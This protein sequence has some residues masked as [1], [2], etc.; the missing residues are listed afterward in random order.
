MADV[1][2]WRACGVADRRGT[3]LDGAGDADDIWRDAR[4][5]LGLG[6]RMGAPVLTGPVMERRVPL[7]IES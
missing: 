5:G 1:V 4:S 3:A 2:D 6:A 7:L